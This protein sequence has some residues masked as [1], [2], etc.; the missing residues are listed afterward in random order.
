MPSGSSG[1]PAPPICDGGLPSKGSRRG[2]ST[3]HTRGINTSACGESTTMG[4][5][6]MA[7]TLPRV[8]V[9][10]EFPT[11][12]LTRTSPVAAR[13]RSLARSSHAELDG[14]GAG[15]ADMCF[16]GNCALAMTVD[17]AVAAP[18]VAQPSLPFAI[19]RKR[20]RDLNL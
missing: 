7:R 1:P 18:V 12:G 6:A 8:C 2:Q 13:L 4:F 14:V 16:A 20:K 19:S 3:Q 15:V 10:R 11:L 9:S 17:N 5:V